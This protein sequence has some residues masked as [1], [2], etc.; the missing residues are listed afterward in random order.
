[1]NDYNIGDIVFVLK[2]KYKSGHEGTAHFFVMIDENQGIEL[3]DYL[4]FLISSNTDKRTYPY[5]RILNKDKV[6]NLRKDSIVKCDD[7]IEIDKSQIAFKIGHVTKEK[8][9]EFIDT[10]QKYLNDY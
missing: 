1:M 3:Y 9:E 5:N 4:G 10:Y 6:N 2:Y 7:L 8:L